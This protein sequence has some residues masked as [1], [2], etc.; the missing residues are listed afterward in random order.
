MVR[1]MKHD[2]Y[3]VNDLIATIGIEEARHVSILAWEAEFPCTELTIQIS[4]FLLPLFD[5]GEPA[6][7]NRF[8]Q[9]AV[10]L[11]QNADDF[12]VVTERAKILWLIHRV[13]SPLCSLEPSCINR[14]IAR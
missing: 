1:H 5:V 4:V 9:E 6:D 11:G 12:N 13:I 2:P 7:V 3:A 10:Y 8:L 14:L